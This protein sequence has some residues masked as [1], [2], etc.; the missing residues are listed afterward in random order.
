MNDVTSNEVF[1]LADLADFDA[2]EI[3]EIRFENLPAGMY[4]FKVVN[5]D[6]GEKDN[7]DGDNRI[8]AEF[9]LEVVEVVSLLKKGIDVD[10]LMGKGHTEK[11]YI[12]PDQGQ[13]KAVEGI[14]RVKAFIA[15]MGVNATGTLAEMVA[16]TV[17]HIF[18]AKITERPNP[19]D[20]SS[21][22]AQ[23]KFLSKGK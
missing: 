9:K 12:V 7:K 23:L 16:S 14:G 17:D 10:S 18:T 19:N 6:L 13:Q 2:T 3:A 15:D 8:I 1:S 11:V 4:G 20:K 5:A 22:Y 21:P